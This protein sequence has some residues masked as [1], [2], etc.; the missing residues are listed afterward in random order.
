[1]LIM[2]KKYKLKKKI[3]INEKNQ[4]KENLLD[5]HN[6]KQEK[7]LFLKRSLKRKEKTSGLK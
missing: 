2:L 4:L 6:Y 5:N 3:K 7:L 1:M